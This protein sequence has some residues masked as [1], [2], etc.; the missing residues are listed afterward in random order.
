MDYSL[1]FCCIR[2]PSWLVVTSSFEKGDRGRNNI[3]QL[4]KSLTVSTNLLRIPCAS[5]PISVQCAT[6]VLIPSHVTRSTSHHS[7]RFQFNANLRIQRRGLSSFYRSAVPPSPLPFLSTQQASSPPRLRNPPL[8]D[9]P[10]PW[11]SE[12][13]KSDF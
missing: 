9:L 6:V 5:E 2:E 7:S 8:R 12:L 1:A 11:P 10:K 13:D 3:I 4:I